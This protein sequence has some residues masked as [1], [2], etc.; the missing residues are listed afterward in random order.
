[1]MDDL[2]EKSL[3]NAAAGKKPE[4]LSKFKDLAEKTG[5]R[6]AKAFGRILIVD[7]TPEIAQFTSLVLRDA[8]HSILN[9]A[10]NGKEGLDYYKSHW[11]EV[12][13]VI[14]DMM[15]P[16]MNGPECLKGM[17]AINPNVRIIIS[18]AYSPEEDKVCEMGIKG[19]IQKPFSPDKLV[20]MV[21]SVLEE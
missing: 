12:D 21:K 20:D 18:S 6:Q 13:I 5:N 19:F 17:N 4:T 8:G 16:E 10:E 7:D 14:L 15:M 1:M 9:I 3:P 2:R 11:Q